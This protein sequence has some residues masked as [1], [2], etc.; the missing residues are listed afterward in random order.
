[1]TQVARRLALA[2]AFLGV[3]LWVGVTPV[4]PASVNQVGDGWPDQDDASALIPP[5][6]PTPPAIAPGGLTA[7]FRVC[8]TPDPQ[9]ERAIEQAVAGRAF[10]VTLVS[11]PDGCAD[12]T[13]QVTSQAAVQGSSRVESTLAISLDGRNLALQVVSANGVTRASLGPER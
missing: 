2:V 12:L 7:T 8:G 11:R 13:I 3:W 4:A 6:L 9:V 10:D 5:C 1:M